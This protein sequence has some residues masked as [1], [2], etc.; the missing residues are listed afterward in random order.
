MQRYYSYTPKCLIKDLSVFFSQNSDLLMVFIFYHV[1]GNKKR[2]N[3]LFVLYE[4]ELDNTMQ[5]NTI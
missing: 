2:T 5:Y 3:M 1:Q 4:A